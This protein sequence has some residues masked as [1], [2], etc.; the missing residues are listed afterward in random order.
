MAHRS[1]ARTSLLR[2]PR[3]TT[4]RRRSAVRRPRLPGPARRTAGPQSG[5]DTSPTYLPRMPSAR[6][7]MA[8]TPMG[9]H[10]PTSSPTVRSKPS[11]RTGTEPNR[12]VH[13]PGSTSARRAASQS[14]GRIRRGPRSR[15]LPA[16]RS[17]ATWPGP[18]DG[19]GFGTILPS[20]RVPARAASSQSPVGRPQRRLAG[21]AG[22]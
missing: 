22:H 17:A 9:H 18:R 7:E 6:N 13:R 21:T 2:H 4:G 3:R 15:S 10:P 20:H 5:L 14:S 19:P 8:R 16:R 11:D 12:P 1:R